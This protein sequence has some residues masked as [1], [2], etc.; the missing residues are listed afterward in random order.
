MQGVPAFRYGLQR[1]VCRVH[2]PGLHSEC[3]LSESSQVIN[4]KI[5]HG[6]ILESILTFFLV[7][8]TFAH[9]RVFEVLQLCS[10][11]SHPATVPPTYQTGPGHER[12]PS[13]PPWTHIWKTLTARKLLATWPFTHLA[14]VFL[15]LRP[16]F[17]QNKHQ[18][19]HFASF[20]N[21]ATPRKL[22]NSGVSELPECWQRRSDETKT[23]LGVVLVSFK[24]T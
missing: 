3:N 11:V 22:P 2:W 12:G 5:Y 16:S 23:N 19:L 13:A 1:A 8:E 21:F 24:Q 14:A 20:S 17:N 18:Q 4:N 9:V 7:P 6:I 15:L 10:P